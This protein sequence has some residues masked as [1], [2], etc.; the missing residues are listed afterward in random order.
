MSIAATVLGMFSGKVG[1]KIMG[2]IDQLVGDKD[3][4]AQLKHSLSMQ[5]LV[6]DQEMAKIELETE[7]DIE[8]AQQAT[9][10]AELQQ[11]D[12]YTKRTRPK[13][14]RQSWYLSMAYM[15]ACLLSSIT[16]PES[17]DTVGYELEFQ[18]EVFVAVASPALQYIGARGFDKWKNPAG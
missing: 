4:N 7:R 10:Q 5:Q 11:N 1:E 17:W 8:V 12:T 18:W 3:L 14:A 15:S 6:G 16:F 2:V 9:I 13:L